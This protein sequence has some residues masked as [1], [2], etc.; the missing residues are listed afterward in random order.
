[1]ATA[2]KVADFVTLLITMVNSDFLSTVT[3][4]CW[5]CS[6]AILIANLQ[7]FCS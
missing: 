4:G 7:Y 6:T 5:Y 3:Q 1:M 2:K